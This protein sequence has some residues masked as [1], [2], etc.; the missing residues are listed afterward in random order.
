MSRSFNFKL[1]LLALVFFSTVNST[2]FQSEN[3]C[4]LHTT[5]ELRCHGNHDPVRIK[6]KPTNIGKKGPKGAPGQKG[7]PG[8][9]LTAEDCLAKTQEFEKLFRQLSSCVIEE[10]TN[11]R[12]NA[13][14]FIR[15]NEHVTYECDSGYFSEN[16]STRKCVMGNLIPSFALYPFQCQLGCLVTRID[17]ASSTPPQGT[18]VKSGSRVSYSCDAGYTTSAQIERTCNGSKLTP[19]FE[20][21]PLACYKDCTSVDNENFKG[22]LNLP[23]SH[24]EAAV[25]TCDAGYFKRKSSVTCADGDVNLDDVC[26]KP[27][28]HLVAQKMSWPDSHEY[29][30]E[31]YNGS[32]AN[33]GMESFAAR[34]KLALDHGLQGDYSVGFKRVSGAWFRADGSDIDPPLD[35]RWWPGHP[36]DHDYV[37]VRAYPKEYPERI[38]LLWVY[39]PEEPLVFFCESWD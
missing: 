31:K 8:T 35:F 3:Q 23:L 20:E 32:L 15:H 1:I 39:F 10:I 19:S 24:G 16:V 33:H 6:N 38:G 17:H 21:E 37:R 2:I 28:Y 26:V 11:A 34:R 36:H 4:Q 30:R 25:V 14:S 9:S 29:C 27:T 5:T 22:T 18:H 12:H 13:S 7:E